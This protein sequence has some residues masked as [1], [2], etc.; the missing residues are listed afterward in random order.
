MS[1]P[2]RKEAARIAKTALAVA[3]AEAHRRQERPYYWWRFHYHR[4]YALPAVRWLAR[5][6][7]RGQANRYA[8]FARAMGDYSCTTIR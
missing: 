1:Y 7:H 4:F 6:Y 8:A 5:A 2:G 3:Q